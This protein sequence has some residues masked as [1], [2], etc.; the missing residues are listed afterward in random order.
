VKISGTDWNS[1]KLFYSCR[2]HVCGFVDLAHPI[3]CPCHDKSSAGNAD[4]VDQV[5]DVADVVKYVEGRL[6]GVETNLET[7]MCDVGTN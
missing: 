2:N 6:L 1:Y 7:T 4:E 5:C 3:G